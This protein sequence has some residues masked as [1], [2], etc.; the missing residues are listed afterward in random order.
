MSFTPTSPYTFNF[1][2]GLDSQLQNVIYN[3]PP[4]TPEVV[5]NLQIIDQ[6]SWL[7]V[8]NVAYFPEDKTIRFIIKVNEA[9]ANGMLEGY[10]QASIRIRYNI[11]SN[12]L[13]ITSDPF[14]IVLNIIQTTL[15]SLN[16]SVLPF[17]Y[18]IGEALPDTQTLNITSGGSWNIT[19]FQSWVTLSQTSGVG[20]SPVAV[21]VNVAGLTPGIYESLL[22]VNDS[23]GTPRE[24]VVTLIVSTGDTEDTYLYVSPN[25]LQFIS[26]LEVENTTQKN[27]TIEASD[28]WVVTSSQPWVELSV[29]SGG[30]GITT[31]IVSVDS[32]ELTD[33]NVPYLAELSFTSQGIQK[34]VFIELIIV[35]FL[36][37]GITSE[38]LYFADDCNKLEVSNVFPNM[39]LYCEAIASNGQENIVYKLNA[40]YQSGVAKQLIGLETN[41]LLQSINP[42]SNLTSRVQHRI[43]P[44]VINLN[45]FNKAKFTGAT[46]PLAN[47]SNLRF[48]RGKTPTTLNKLCYIPSIVNVTKDAVLSLSA[49]NTSEA[50]TQINISGD[51]TATISTSIANNLLTYNAI[52]NLSTLDLSSGD[53]I[54]INWANIEVLV[55][56]KPNPIDHHIIAFENEWLEL[57]FFECTGFL[58]IAPNAKQ[59][60]TQL[61]IEGTKQTKIVSIDNGETYTL[62]TGYIYTQA[63]FNWLSRILESKRVYIYL[64]GEAVEIVLDSKSL[65]TYKTREHFRAYN[66]KFTKAIIND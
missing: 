57:E 36:L 9:Y 59:T 21:G 34:T 32:D 19:A 11:F 65:V 47:Y 40:P 16:P 4:L 1:L 23:L 30:S 26:E 39:Q 22:V 33:I 12:A 54:T 56:I 13:T 6:P 10:H 41:V 43:N 15:L 61:Q 18:N 63:E 14:E 20:S 60:K 44:I 25:N 3:A 5:T 28:A 17:N 37:Q 38:A 35:P 24:A 62:N 8:L 29:S 31:I 2:Q 27:I 42:L 7:T 64:N 58:T 49:L 53:Q 50:P 52:V 66:L 45:V 55:N 46:T 51:A 48:L